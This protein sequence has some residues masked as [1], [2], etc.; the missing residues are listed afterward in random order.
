MVPPGFAA[1]SARTY[2]DLDL[3]TAD[4]PHQAVMPRP[5]AWPAT[6]PAA[7]TNALAVASLA[8]GFGQFLIGP[9]A[10][11]PAIALG[12][13]ARHQIKQTGEQGAMMALVGL[14]LGWAAVILALVA[15][16]VVSTFASAG[17]YGTMPMP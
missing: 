15:L 2:A 4:L 17:M 7:R 11:I 16:I 6:A 12:H 3:L 10:T 13:M 14:T 5:A 8:C 9:L 1:F